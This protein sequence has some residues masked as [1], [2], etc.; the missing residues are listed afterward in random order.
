MYVVRSGSVYVNRVKILAIVQ[1]STVE[2]GIVTGRMILFMP[3][4]VVA[5]R[6]HVIHFHRTGFSRN[7]LWFN[8]NRFQLQDII[9]YR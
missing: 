5:L 1:A 7:E 3:K 8:C 4:N 2:D 9:G 6:L